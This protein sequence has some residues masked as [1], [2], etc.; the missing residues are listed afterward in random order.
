MNM[1]DSNGNLTEE[2]KKQLS[3]EE[4]AMFDALPRVSATWMME[5]Q[6]AAVR[7]LSAAMQ[8]K[9]LFDV[10]ERGRQTTTQANFIAKLAVGAIV[11]QTLVELILRSL[12]L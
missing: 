9:A 10:E 12:G 2:A 8:R 1:L 5:R 3:P 11:I 7:L 6:A 4:V